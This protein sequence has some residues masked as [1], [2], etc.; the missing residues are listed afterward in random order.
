MV[1]QDKLI[2]LL[3]ETTDKDNLRVSKWWQRC[4]HPMSS[5]CGPFSATT[6]STTTLN[7]YY[8][9]IASFIRLKQEH[10]VI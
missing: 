9:N 1:T 3:G 10:L 4:I 6:T 5:N 8:Y 2:Q 7:Y